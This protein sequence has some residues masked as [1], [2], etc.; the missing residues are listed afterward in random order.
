M[1]KREL[2]KHMMSLGTYKVSRDDSL[3]TIEVKEKRF[4]VLYLKTSK[5]TQITVNSPTVIEVAKGK[6]SGIRYKKTSSN[7]YRFDSKEIDVLVVCTGK[8]YRILKHLNEN[9]IEDIT[10]D[11]KVHKI[12]FLYTLEEI[13]SIINETN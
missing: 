5:D 6:L 10:I 13:Q 4:K 2:R 8:P 7:L 3:F 9:Q 11:N 12:H 1:N